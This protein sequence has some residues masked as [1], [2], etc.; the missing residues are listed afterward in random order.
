[1]SGRGS[2]DIS[3]R[4]E[5]HTL[6]PRCILGLSQSAEE[7]SRNQQAL[8]YAAHSEAVVTITLKSR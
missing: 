2:Q 7:D 1:M 5:A 4:P 6:L 3:L 8:G